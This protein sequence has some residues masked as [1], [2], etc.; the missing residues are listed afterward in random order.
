MVSKNKFMMNLYENIQ[1]AIQADKKDGQEISEELMDIYNRASDDEMRLI[2][3]IFVALTGWS[4]ETLIEGTK[5][6]D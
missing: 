6:H 2:N 5:N 4:L 1:S 3:T